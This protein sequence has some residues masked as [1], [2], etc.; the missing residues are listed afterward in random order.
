MKRGL[1]GGRLPDNIKALNQQ[2]DGEFVQ[3]VDK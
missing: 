2:L 3:S 1:G